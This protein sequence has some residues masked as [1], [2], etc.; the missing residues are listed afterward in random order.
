DQLLPQRNTPPAAD[1]GKIFSKHRRED[2]STHVQESSFRFGWKTPHDLR[3]GWHMCQ[4]GYGE[5]TGNAACAGGR[6]NL[7][8]IFSGRPRGASP[9]INAGRNAAEIASGTK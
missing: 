1:L 5:S 8:R 3:L 6:K 9:P 4:C 7:R 2:D